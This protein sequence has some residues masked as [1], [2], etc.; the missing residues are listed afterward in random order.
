MVDSYL[1][2]VDDLV[3]RYHKGEDKKDGSFETPVRQ[4]RL[5]DDPCQVIVA[6][7]YDSEGL[8]TS[9]TIHLTGTIGGKPIDALRAVSLNNIPDER[10]LHLRL[11]LVN[12]VAKIFLNDSSHR[13]SRK[14]ITS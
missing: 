12:A 10:T 4:V 3:T 13:L 2:R 5:G 11:K 14:T 9:G 7:D 8:I 1:K 6:A